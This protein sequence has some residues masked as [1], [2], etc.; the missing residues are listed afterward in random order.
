MSSLSGK[1]CIFEVFFIIICVL[2]NQKKRPSAIAPTAKSCS[3]PDPELAKQVGPRSSKDLRER[4]WD[5]QI[6]IVMPGDNHRQAR[7]GQ[8]L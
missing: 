1:F 2:H 6:F 4:V 5:F 3:L 8:N 7:S